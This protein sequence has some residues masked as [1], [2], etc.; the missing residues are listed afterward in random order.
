MAITVLLVDD[1]DLV[2]MGVRSLLQ[3]VK[4]IQVVGEAKDG[5]E[6]I[7]QARA[8]KPNVI[9]M[10]VG[11]PGIGGLEA[12][13]RLVQHDATTKVLILSAHGSEPYPSRVLK[14][15]ALGY[16]TKG[17]SA[18]EMMTAIRSVYAGKRYISA[19]VAQQL[20]MKQLNVEGKTPFDE[21]SEREMQIVIMIT[22]GQ[23]VGDIADQLF[24]SP[25]TVN[26]Y[27]YRIFEKLDITSDVELT[28]LAMRHGL[29][30]S[31]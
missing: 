29:I 21:L 16:I 25:K 15:G 30:E 19:E 24:L 26:S 27:R 6:A 14:A 12:T 22:S 3:G 23:K 9:V 10:D 11:M 28:R 17:T 20:A 4:D 1:H 7:K 18:E 31:E 2:R 5:E 13:K 8:L